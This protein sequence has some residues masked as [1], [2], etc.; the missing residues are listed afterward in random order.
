M[1]CLPAGVKDIT[2]FRGIKLDRGKK[3]RD[4]KALVAL[5]PWILPRNGF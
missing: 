4:K 2:W 3:E 5:H 1:S